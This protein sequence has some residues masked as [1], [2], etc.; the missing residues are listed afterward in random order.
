MRRINDAIVY[1][2]KWPSL[3][4]QKDAIRGLEELSSTAAKECI[5]EFNRLMRTV[6][7]AVQFQ[8]R[9]IY[10]PPPLNPFNNSAP[11][12]SSRRFLM[13]SPVVHVFGSRYMPSVVPLST[14][15]N[16]LCANFCT[17][18]ALQII[19]VVCSRWSLSRHRLSNPAVSSHVRARAFAR[20]VLYL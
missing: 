4:S 1:F 15:V 16:P 3:K 11:K 17:E 5:D 8:A 10:H 14:A 19:F 6:G 9:A 20:T 2:R 13:Y 18:T 7:P 12:V